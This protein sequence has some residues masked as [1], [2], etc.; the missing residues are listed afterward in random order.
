M[1]QFG[2]ID[3]NIAEIALIGTGGGYGE[4]CVIHLG[5]NEW[6]IIDSCRDPKTKSILPI[7]YL[8]EINVPFENVKL[9]LCTHWHDDHIQGLS[10]ILKECAN[11]DFSFAKA[12]DLKKF[13]LL[14]S[15]DYEK[16]NRDSSL[17][18][19]LEF[20]E[21]LEIL[22][23]RNS[24]PKFAS[25]D[26]M[27][28][29]KEVNGQKCEVFTLSPSDITL[30]K[31]DE[32]ISTLISEFGPP[33]RKIIANTPNSK[34]VVSFIKFGHHRALLGA[35]LEIS[36]DLNEG[37]DNILLNC[38]SIDMK[39]SLFK[40]PH[41]GSENSYHREIWAEM[42]SQNPIAALTPW[43]KKNG[44]PQLQ[45]LQKF[46][47]HT[48]NLYITSPKVNLKPKKRHRS[49]EKLIKQLNQKLTEVK[50]VKGVIQCRIKID[51]PNDEWKVS[52]LYS[53]MK[54]DSN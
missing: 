10:K 31:F 15:L 52:P 49:V 45:M 13:L 40:I 35:D 36:A 37:W 8:K 50:F 41:H 7:E 2:F 19:T 38:K 16:I 54:I 44:L 20:T 18:S 25:Q 42:L 22:K 21:C 39:A 24:H 12:N 3:P 30:Q 34:S 5:N 29:A 28:W 4:S 47:T 27:L 23:K 53:S 48:D 33:N 9:I 6:M 26:R 14:I 46:Q 32:E 1:N 43:N 11:A 17:S 51:D